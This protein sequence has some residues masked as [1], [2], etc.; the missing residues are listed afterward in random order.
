MSAKIVDCLVETVGVTG[1]LL[2]G[3]GRLF[4]G[5]VFMVITATITGVILWFSW[6]LLFGE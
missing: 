6:L 1:N 2:D 4:T 5:I 3:I